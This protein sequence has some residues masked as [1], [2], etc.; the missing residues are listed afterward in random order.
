[1]ATSDRE[2]NR[3]QCGAC[4]LQRT[5]VLRARWRQRDGA[6]AR[7]HECRDCGHRF[8]STEHADPPR[9]AQTSSAK[10]SILR[11]SHPL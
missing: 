3:L 5:H 4:G 2:P 1:M 8:N 7:R 11:T 9:V 10:H 6:I